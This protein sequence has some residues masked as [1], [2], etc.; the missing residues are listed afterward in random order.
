M[1]AGKNSYNWDQVRPRESE[2]NLIGGATIGF[3]AM[4]YTDHFM[5]DV[6]NSTWDQHLED[7]LSLFESEAMAASS[8]QS[9]ESG[10]DTESCVS[11][12][13][14][15]QS[16]FVDSN[17]TIQKQHTSQIPP[18]QTPP[19]LSEYCYMNLDCGDLEYENSSIMNQKMTG[20]DIH[21]NTGNFTEMDY[22]TLSNQ[23]QEFN[24]QILEYSDTKVFT[25][26]E[27]SRSSPQG[28]Q[29]IGNP[30]L[31]PVQCVQPG[32]GMD[33]GFTPVNNNPRPA[34]NMSESSFESYGSE[35]EILPSCNIS[36]LPS[37]KQ[38]FSRG[39]SMYLTN[40]QI[41]DILSKSPPS[42]DEHVAMRVKTECDTNLGSCGENQNGGVSRQQDFWKPSE[43]IKVE[44]GKG[45]VSR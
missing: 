19:Q 3:G 36:H 15:P 14:S 30:Q 28:I 8:P 21:T 2:R 41:S 42:Y 16:Y 31:P 40:Q 44:E 26:L 35:A 27:C 6:A 18:L 34:S 5:V 12:C 1:F 9:P 25:P 37:S 33:M 43:A 23:L 20:R 32:M 4:M 22:N 10:S 38:D 24:H 39:G 7:C 13:G 17:V 45:Y 11:S 29:Y